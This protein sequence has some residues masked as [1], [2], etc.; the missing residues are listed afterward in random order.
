MVYDMW[1]PVRAPRIP[2]RVRVLFRTK[3]RSAPLSPLESEGSR[4]VIDAKEVAKG[5]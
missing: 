4:G 3:R 5:F 2:V 1:A